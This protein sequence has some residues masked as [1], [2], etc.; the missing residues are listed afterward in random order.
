MLLAHMVFDLPAPALVAVGLSAVL[1]HAYSPFLGWHGG[2]AI[3]V[4]F[5]VLLAFIVCMVFGFLFIESD[6]WT[7]VI[8]AAGTSIYSGITHGGWD[9]LL[10]VLMLAVLTVKQLD[11]LHR[12]PGLKGRLLRW[13]QILVKVTLSII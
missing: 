13:V 4:T 10:M 1:G 7:V 6:S 12:L 9:T 2:K 8:G 11:S 5:G 3:A